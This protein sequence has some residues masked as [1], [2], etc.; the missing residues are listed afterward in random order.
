MALLLG[1]CEAELKDFANVVARFGGR[2]H[3]ALSVLE[4]PVGERRGFPS[5]AALRDFALTQWTAQAPA[6][7]CCWLEP[8]K[9]IEDQLT[10]LVAAR[11]LSHWASESTSPL[12]A[13]LDERR[14][15]T[16][17][18]PVFSGDDL[19]IWGY[20]CLARAVDDDGEVIPP[21][22]LFRW[23]RDENLIF[24]LDRVCREQHIENF[25]TA[26]IPA[27]VACLINFLP[28]VIYDPAVCLRSTF[29]TADRVGLT[30]SRV[31]FEVVETEQI[32]DRDHLRNILDEYRGAGFR[33][34]LDDVGAGHAGISL[35]GDLAPDVVKIDRGLVKNCLTS[36]VYATICRSIVEITRSAGKCVLAEGIE[37]PEEYAFFR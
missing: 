15:L 2:Y 29:K 21:A 25:A 1:G 26:Q 27:H 18:Q 30:P 5:V 20:E 12:R 13:I 19:A 28:T 9:P 23:A 8:G 16:W 3:E 35:I 24:M 34:A 22:D 7:R 4:L 37:T 6:L 14:I 10:T 11:P 17:F 36:P 31:V 32:A 33:I